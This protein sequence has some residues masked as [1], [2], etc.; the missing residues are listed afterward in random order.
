MFNG[1]LSTDRHGS[2]IGSG[3]GSLFDFFT[4]PASIS[5]LGGTL[6]TRVGAGLAVRDVSHV[7]AGDYHSG[8]FL[9]NITVLIQIKIVSCVQHCGGVFHR[10]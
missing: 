10:K 5:F 2:L 4:D 8:L 6:R 7:T 9:G 3:M 1:C